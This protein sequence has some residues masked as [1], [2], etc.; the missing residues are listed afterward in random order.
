MK[1]LKQ[2]RSDVSHNVAH[3]PTPWQ[4]RISLENNYAVDIWNTDK[5]DKMRLAKGVTRDDAAFI[6][7]A[8]NLHKELVDIVNHFLFLQCRDYD[9]SVWREANERAQ[10]IIAK[11]EGK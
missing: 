6:V 11:A 2:E 1:N 3:T 7:L 9:D 8:V 10:A 5:E 4:F